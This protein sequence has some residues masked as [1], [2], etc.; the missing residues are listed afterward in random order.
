[1][2]RIPLRGTMAA[3]TKRLGARM[4]SIAYRTALVVAGLVVALAG[5]LTLSAYAQTSP[6]TDHAVFHVGGPQG[7]HGPARMIEHMLDSA[8]A[9]EQQ[10]AQVKQIPQ[11][12]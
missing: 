10:P 12:P 5:T 4:K 2:G 9:T 8:N 11:A 3:P 1:M 6:H 7:A